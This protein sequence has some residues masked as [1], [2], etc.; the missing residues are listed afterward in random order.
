M[1]LKVKHN[2]L[3][4]SLWAK[5]EENCQQNESRRNG[6]SRKP[7]IDPASRKPLP[8]A[9]ENPSQKSKSAEHFIGGF[10]YKK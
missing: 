1:L 7:L 2:R 4:N 6:V 9:F 3:L 10:C 5:S 8:H